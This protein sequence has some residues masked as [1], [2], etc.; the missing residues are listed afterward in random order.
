MIRIA[1][2]LA[3][4]LV[5]AAPEAPAQRRSRR[6]AEPSLPVASFVLG[7]QA[8]R[9]DP[10]DTR[11]GADYWQVRDAR[12]IPP[13]LPLDGTVRAISGGAN[14]YVDQPLCR[15]VPTLH[16]YLGHERWGPVMYDNFNGQRSKLIQQVRALVEANCEPGVVQTVQLALFQPTFI[17]TRENGRYLDRYGDEREGT[18][19]GRYVYLGAVVVAEGY[20]LYH[21]DANGLARYLATNR[22][23]EDEYARIAASRQAEEYLRQEGVGGLLRDLCASNPL[24]CAGIVATAVYP[25]GGAPGGSNAFQ[26]CMAECGFRPPEQQA[27]CR[28]SCGE[29]VTR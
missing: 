6:S 19:A 12:V 22:A 28:S 17:F 27:F 24:P 2:L 23:S 15:S 13:A 8:V 3:L 11:V 9:I 20:A 21:D 26:M 5:L 4:A 25:G 16:V 14:A 7:D 18:Q 10:N 1:A 29:F